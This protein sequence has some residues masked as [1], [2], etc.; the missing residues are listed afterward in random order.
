MHITVEFITSTLR[1]MC[2][3]AD[4]TDLSLLTAELLTDLMA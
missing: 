4:V 1:K 2:I 3:S